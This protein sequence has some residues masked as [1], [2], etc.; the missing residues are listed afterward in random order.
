M[1]IGAWLRMCAACRHTSNSM[2]CGE[3]GA[4]SI[5]VPRYDQE[6]AS[7]GGV[8]MVTDVVQLSVACDSAQAQRVRQGHAMGRDRRE[9]PSAFGDKSPALDVDGVLVLY[10]AHSAQRSLSCTSR[11]CWCALHPRVPQ[12]PS[13]NPQADNSRLIYRPGAP[14]APGDS[15]G[16]SRN[17]A[18]LGMLRLWVQPLRAVGGISP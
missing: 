6:L 15:P 8:L 12:P 16:Q 17:R 18:D 7:N 3:R 13:Q 1:Q 5:E 10:P 2:G 11:K 14:L 9:A 4:C